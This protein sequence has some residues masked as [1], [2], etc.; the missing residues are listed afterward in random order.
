V[1]PQVLEQGRC[2]SSE[3]ALLSPTTDPLIVALPIRPV[4]DSWLNGRAPRLPMTSR[5]RWHPYP[6]RSEAHCQPAEDWRR[7]IVGQLTSE[8]G[9]RCVAVADAISA[10]GAQAAFR[11]EG[12]PAGLHELSGST[13]RRVGADLALLVSH[14]QRISIPLPDSEG[15]LS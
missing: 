12:G 15:G 9:A 7:E 4:R 2:S 10:D 3:A 14:A 6:Q 5:R 11:E 8:V 13:V 1:V